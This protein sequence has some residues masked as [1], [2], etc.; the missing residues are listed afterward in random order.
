MERHDLWSQHLKQGP[1]NTRSKIWVRE[2]SFFQCWEG[3]QGLWAGTFCGSEE[4]SSHRH[5]QEPLPISD[6]IPTDHR[7]REAEH[8]C[9]GPDTP[10]H[11][12]GAWED[13]FCAHTAR[14]VWVTQVRWDS[15]L[16]YVKESRRSL[17][18][19]YYSIQ[20][21]SMK[22]I[23]FCLLCLFVLFI[24][25]CCCCVWVFF[26]SLPSFLTWLFWSTPR[27]R[28]APGPWG[29][30]ALPGPSAA[31]TDLGAQGEQTT[32]SAASPHPVYFINT[33]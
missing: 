31:A 20:L 8:P 15:G 19:Y 21:A 22:I 26:S 16:Q 10:R 13:L 27:S 32:L 33:E 17:F 7:S 18:V 1:A 3:L 23:M 14:P 5:V 28:F 25:I 11:P 30:T 4:Q 9:S 12:H 2:K 24:F 6:H 29:C